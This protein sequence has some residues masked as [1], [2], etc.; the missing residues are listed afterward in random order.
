[1]TKISKTFIQSLTNIPNSE[2]EKNKA[3]FEFI[4]VCIQNIYGYD[5]PA[6]I[7]SNSGRIIKYREARKILFYMVKSNTGMTFDEISKKLFTTDAVNIWRIYTNMDILMR[8]R[9]ENDTTKKIKIIQG[10]LDLYITEWQRENE[11]EK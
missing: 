6:E 9:L 1:M 2:Y 10:R 4:L 5:D 11:L 3:I 7:L 8:K